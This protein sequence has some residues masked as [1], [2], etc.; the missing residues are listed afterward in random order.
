MKPVKAPANAI[1]SPIASWKPSFAPSL[2]TLDKIHKAYSSFKKKTLAAG[3]KCEKSG[4]MGWSQACHLWSSLVLLK[5]LDMTK[6][7]VDRVQVLEA[8]E[9]GLK[10]EIYIQRNT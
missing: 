3:I 9:R 5:V 2:Y 7:M 10:K 4:F 8:V 1:S 6:L